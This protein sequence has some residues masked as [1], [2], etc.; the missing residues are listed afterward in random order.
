MNLDTPQK[1]FF[2]DHPVRCGMA[3]MALAVALFTVMDAIAKGL[4]QEYH[5]IQVM[6]F[7]AVGVMLPLTIYTMRQP[8]KFGLWRTHQPVRSLICGVCM[9]AAMA[10]LF[11]SYQA[12]PLTSAYTILYSMPI[13]AALLAVPMLG[14][15]L[16]FGAL[17]AILTGFAGVLLMVWHGGGF[18]IDRISGTGLAMLAALVGA[19]FYALWL[20]LVRQLSRTDSDPGIVFSNNLVMTLATLMPLPFVWQNPESGLA[21]LGMAGIGI[22]GGIAQIVMTRAFTLG[23]ARAIAPFEYSS[24]IW[25]VLIDWIFW[26]VWPQYSVIIG[27]VLVIGSGM[28]I[29]FNENRDH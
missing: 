22:L 26:G 3:L 10:G 27:A 28:W 1:R 29:A 7:R 24:M 6:F 13:W 21:M 20:I 14:E 17:L 16:R 23:P 4:M 15:R 18:D 12:L 19:I 25:V 11:F 9:L 8:G 5:P 2:R